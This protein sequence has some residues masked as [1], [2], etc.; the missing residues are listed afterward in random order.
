MISPDRSVE[1]VMRER[2]ELHSLTKESHPL[3]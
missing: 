1:T 2:G 3:Q